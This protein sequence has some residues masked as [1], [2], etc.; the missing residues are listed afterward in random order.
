V[1]HDLVGGSGSYIPGADAVFPEGLAIPH[2]V[3]EGPDH[4]VTFHVHIPI[5]EGMLGQDYTGMLQLLHEDVNMDDV[6]VTVMLERGEDYVRIYPN[7][8]KASEC[9]D[10]TIALGG[11]EGEVEVKVY[12]MFGGLVADLTQSGARADTDIQW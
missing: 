2:E 11:I 8:V 7:P 1:M 6:S 3:E 10:V 12:D 4:W 9:D 5:P